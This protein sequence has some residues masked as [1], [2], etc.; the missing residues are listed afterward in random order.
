MA[1]TIKNAEQYQLA[2]VNIAARARTDKTFYAALL[3]DPVNT[4]KL[5]G[6]GTDAAHELLSEDAFTRSRIGEAADGNN[7]SCICASNQGCCVT[8]WVVTN[9]NAPTQNVLNN[10]LLVNFGG[11]DPALRVTP[12]R[13]QLVSRLVDQGHLF[14]N[15]NLK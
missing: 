11:A 5:E 6:I 10:P 14:P 12:E 13:A 8:C 2:A 4:L 9:S 1:T 3:R 15:L 7:V